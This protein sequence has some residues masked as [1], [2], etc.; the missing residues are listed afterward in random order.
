MMR[1]IELAVDGH[2]LVAC[3]VNEDKGGVPIVFLHGIGASVNFWVTGMTPFI[4]EHFRWY[5]LSLP[6][7]YPA[8]VPPAFSDADVNAE[9]LASLTLKALNQLVGDSPVLLFG[10][11]T[12]GFLALDVA[13]H[14]P[15]RVK[16]VFCLSG[17]AHGRWTGALGLFQ[18]LAALPVAGG[19]LFS[20]FYG[21]VNLISQD[22]FRF[23]MRLY[24]ADSAAMYANT[25]FNSSLSTLYASFRRLDY[26]AVARYFRRMPQVDITP[27]LGRI[28]APVWAVT[29]D[30]DGIVPPA[31]AQTIAAGVRQ[32]RH[33]VIPGAGHLPMVE[34]EALYSSLVV[35]WAQ[36]WL[37]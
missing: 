37:H 18:Q 19:A 15:E 36:Q 6:G 20:A 10:H 13:A 34:R 7:H 31:Q 27:L 5:A 22:V 28:Q 3:A 21:G 33:I 12:G 8:R 25:T 26:P 1:T 14:A 17:F 35:E 24:T 23:N 11:S 4:N 30:H 32:G 9:S 16:G 29:G 2:T